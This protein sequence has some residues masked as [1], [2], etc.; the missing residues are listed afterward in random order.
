MTR[1]GVEQLDWARQQRTRCTLCPHDCRVNRAIGATGICGAAGQVRYFRLFRHASANPGGGRCETI[2][3]QGCNLRCRFCHTAAEAAAVP[4]EVLT[5]A[6]LNAVL[7]GN[8]AGSGAVELNLLGGEPLVHLPGL[9]PLLANVPVKSDVVFNTNLYCA[10]ATV[11]ILAAVADHCIVDVKFWSESCAARLAAAPGYRKVVAERLLELAARNPARLTVR[12]LALP[13]HFHCCTRPVLQWLA[14]T[15]PGIAVHL[16]LD[17]LVMPA[18][19][20]D[21]DLGRFL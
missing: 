8:R 12:H 16:K 2:Y 3:L 5:S 14:A 15:L 6:R 11:P 17:Y 7:A 4:G 1:P 18:A 9:L 10:A 19:R 21:R 13:G 20:S